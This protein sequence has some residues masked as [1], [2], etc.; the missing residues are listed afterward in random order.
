M[1]KADVGF[2]FQSQAEFALSLGGPH[3]DK[4]YFELCLPYTHMAGLNL[5]V[6]T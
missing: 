3:A 4:A 6:Q 2:G 5:G 1:T